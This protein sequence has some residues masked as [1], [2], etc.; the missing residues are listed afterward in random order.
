[1]SKRI[2]TLK[3][4][5]KFF[6]AIW[7]GERVHDL[8]RNDRDFEVG[9]VCE[10][11]EYDPVLAKYSGRALSILVTSITSAA[12]PCAVSEMALH[13][14]FCILSIRRVL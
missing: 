4:W 11:R 13:S 14:D 6:D 8:R 7:Q 5:P 10:L 9:D 1:M 12:K 2:H 3:S